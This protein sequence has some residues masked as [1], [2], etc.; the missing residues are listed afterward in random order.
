[1]A[2]NVYSSEYASA[3]LPKYPQK[4]IEEYNKILDHLLKGEDPIDV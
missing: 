2:E 1:M 3:E 4:T